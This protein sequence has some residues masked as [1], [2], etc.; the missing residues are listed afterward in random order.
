MN[1]S[2]KDVKADKKRIDSAAGRDIEAARARAAEH[3]NALVLGFRLAEL[4]AGARLSQTEL[5][6]RMGVSQA[7]ISQ[8][9]H[10]DVSQ[11]ALDTIR[12]YVAAVGGRLRVVADFDDHNE[13]ISTSRVDQGTG[14]AV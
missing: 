2:W 5:A 6:R 14:A 12:R 9:E 8:L 4:R 13:V 3:T 7:R 11:L 10:G 1:R